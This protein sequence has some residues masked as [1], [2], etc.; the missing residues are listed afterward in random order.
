MTR[1]TGAVE[2]DFTRADL[3]ELDAPYCRI[4]HRLIRDVTRWSVHYEGVLSHPDGTFW[5]LL[6]QTP[7]GESGDCDQWYGAPVIRATRA[8]LCEVTSLQWMVVNDE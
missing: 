1:V 8:E 6:W 4:V 5:W 2:R 3:E 7:A